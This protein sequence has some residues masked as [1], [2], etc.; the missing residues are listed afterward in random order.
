MSMVYHSYDS[1]HSAVNELV[2]GAYAEHVGTLGFDEDLSSISR[3]AVENRV[4]TARILE[5]EEKY[6][7]KTDASTTY[8]AKSN[9]A[10]ELNTAIQ[11]YY[12]VGT[13]YMN[14]RSS[15][16]PFDFGTWQLINAKFLYGCNSSFSDLRETGGATTVTLST[17][18]LPT[19]NIPV[20][21]PKIS[22]TTDSASTA[23][24]HSFTT[25]TTTNNQ[26]IFRFRHN[27]D[28]E[29][30]EGWIAQK[31][32]GSCKTIQDGT[33]YRSTGYVTATSGDNAIE[34]D[35]N[36]NH[37]G[38]TGGMSGNEKHSHSFSIPTQSLNIR[39]NSGTQNSFSIVPPYYKVAIWHRTA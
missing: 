6:L 16:V 1:N 4:I 14:D 28:F 26:C 32:A 31:I 24:S 27:T 7:L 8:V 19:S 20:T 15:S 5:D 9:F 18:H 36:H 21:F 30:D 25:D 17:S 38:N 12:P 22:G 2:A 11:T 23:H 29:D 37:G 10:K 35:F 13:I 33:A 39:I 3:N 34:I